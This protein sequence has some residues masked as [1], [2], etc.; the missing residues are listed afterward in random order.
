MLCLV[1]M[2]ILF[3]PLRTVSPMIEPD[4]QF[5]RPQ[6]ARTFARA[7][8]LPTP[9]DVGLRDGVFLH[10][11]QG[12]GKTT[13]L[14]EDLT[15]ALED[16]GAFVVYADLQKRA[17]WRDPDK[18]LA[19]AINAMRQKAAENALLPPADVSSSVP[20]DSIGNAL[21]ETIDRSGR[22]LVLILDGV[23]HL[24]QTRSG[25]SLLKWLKAARDA[26]NLRFRNEARTY[27]LVVAAGSHRYAREQPGIKLQRGLLRSPRQA[28][29]RAGRGLRRLGRGVLFYGGFQGDFQAYFGRSPVSS[30]TRRPRQ[31]V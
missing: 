13:F 2:A 9:F 31:G 15:P 5:R 24:L 30:D 6:E 14:R 18:T 26:V 8:I 21:F 19:K 4:A 28:L 20:S 16:E 22:S 3:F 29:S 17:A 1:L 23:E 11:T 25:R 27:Q 10:G 7:L 12:I